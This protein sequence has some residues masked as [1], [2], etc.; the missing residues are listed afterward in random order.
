MLVSAVA[1]LA[2]SLLRLRQAPRAGELI[3]WAGGHPATEQRTRLRR[4]QPALVELEQHFSAE[5]ISAWMER[6]RRLDL[7]GVVD[8]LLTDR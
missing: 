3:A 4:I 8:G 6:G 7:A 2:F 1:G 5:Q